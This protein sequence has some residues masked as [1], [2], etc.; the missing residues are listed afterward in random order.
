MLEISHLTKRYGKILAVDDVS[1]GVETGRVTGFVGPNGA[2]KTTTLRALL[3]LLTPTSGTATIDGQPFRALPD[4]PRQVG[5]VLETSSFHPGR[6]GRN[7]L[8][9]VAKAAG[10]P[11]GRV[12]EVLELVGLTDAAKRR[13]KS[14]SLGMR[15]RLCL[16]TALLADPRILVLDEPANGLDPEGI[17]WL[18]GFLRSL[19]AE[20]RTILVSSHVL[21]E[22]AQTADDV[23]VIARGRLVAHAPIAELVARAGARTR[24]RAPET[25][26]LRELLGAAGIQATATEDGLLLVDAP[27]ERV[28]E[29]AAANAVVLHELGTESSSLEEV[30]LE[31]TATEEATPG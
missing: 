29:I 12:D 24:V 31:L 6:S 13:G 30:F 5:A 16:A 10:V 17:R 26:R 7:H 2:G 20:G 28:G 9:V 25:D 19:A 15:Q 3:G 1:F 22:L 23:A 21:S 14:Y 8:R 4:P 27:P 18:R 11:R